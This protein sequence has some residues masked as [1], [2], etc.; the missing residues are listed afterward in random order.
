MHGAI[1]R[2]GGDDPANEFIL[3]SGEN[4]LLC[5]YHTGRRHLSDSDQLTLEFAGV[6]RHYH[7]C[8]MR[9]IIVGNPNPQQLAMHQ[10]CEEAMHACQNTLKPG[11]TA[12][13]V[14]TAHAP[15]NGRK[16]VSKYANERLWIQLRHHIRAD[17]DGLANVLCGQSGC[18]STEHDIFSAH[19]SV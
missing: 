3:G 9:T 7:A 15:G 16:W 10:A 2:G 5:R 14:F 19:D 6:Y 11:A 17:L 12:G 8:L 13:E 18:N 4:A 1:Y